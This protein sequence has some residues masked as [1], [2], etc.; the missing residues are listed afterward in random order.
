MSFD[1]WRLLRMDEKLSAEA[2][3]EAVKEL[4]NDILS[5]SGH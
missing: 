4:V 1:T 2:T 5:R 3:V